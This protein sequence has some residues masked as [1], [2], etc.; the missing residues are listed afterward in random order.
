MPFCYQ[1]VI[2]L[3]NISL[4]ERDLY[5]KLFNVG[6]NPTQIFIKRLKEPNVSKTKIKK[7]KKNHL[8][9]NNI[10]NI[11]EQYINSKHFLNENDKY[12]EKRRE[13]TIYDA[14]RLVEK[15]KNP[16]EKYII[17]IYKNMIYVLYNFYSGEIF[18]INEWKNKNL[19]EI[20]NSEI[21]NLIVPSI[22]D[23]SEITAILIEKRFIFFGTRLGSIFIYNIKKNKINKI[24]HNHTKKIY[25]IAYNSY[26]Y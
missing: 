15:L 11:I 4:E 12:D 1:G 22:F 13:K 8:M 5:L 20:R 3:E 2:N 14:K 17:Q 26:L 16:N 25:S 24:I 9:N 18:I 21:K 19:F 7:E 10:I 6:V 23:N